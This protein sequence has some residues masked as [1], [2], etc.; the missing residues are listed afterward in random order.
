MKNLIL[1]LFVSKFV[2][3][4]TLLILNY[5]TDT[6]P[7]TMEK[8]YTY[9]TE[10]DFQNG[11]T[12]HREGYGVSF[13]LFLFKE[14][15][16][17]WLLFSGWLIKLENYLQNFAKDSNV[18]RDILYFSTLILLQ[19]LIFLPFNYYFGY[20]LEHKFGFSNMSL[21]FWIWTELKSLF[22]EFVF[23]IPSALVILWVIQKFE[24][25][26]FWIVPTGGLIFGF[27]MTLLYPVLI[28]PMFY[29]VKPIE[30]GSLKQGIL[31]LSHKAEIE[32]S[33]I[34]IILES[35]YSKHTNA[36]FTGF[37]KR[38]KIYLYDTLIQNHSEKEIL[39]VLTHEIGHWKYDHNLWG[40]VL[41]FISSL[42]LF[43]LLFQFYNTL[44]NSKFLIL[45]SSPTNLVVLAF[46]YQLLSYFLNPL[47]STVS[48][49]ME[50]DADKFA[51]EITSDPTSFIESEIKMAKDN[52]SLLNPHPW[53]TFFYSSHP[54][55]LE[56][57]QLGES[58]KNK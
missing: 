7:E 44:K 22:L 25:F 5:L 17:L 42:V 31:E 18:F 1:S 34:N 56:R 28:L 21:G 46:L 29:E 41:E 43:F 6:R 32:F 38:K 33:E 12:Y 24:R 55:T 15:G 3:K 27:F 39:S 50:L 19:F 10:E 54:T 9:F 53:V 23:T 14:L 30:E 51:I 2:I 36:F 52:K 8:V 47:D 45:E 37:G 20:E 58:Y 11:L 48:R 26:W 16:F 40:I 35:E 13:V 4:L 49:K 57:I